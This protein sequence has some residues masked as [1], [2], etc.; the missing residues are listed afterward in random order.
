MIIWDWQFDLE[1]IMYMN[2]EPIYA[3][4]LVGQ[5]QGEGQD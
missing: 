3:T 5:D 1:C 4:Y 2:F